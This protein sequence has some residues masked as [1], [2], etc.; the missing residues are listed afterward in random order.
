M[1]GSFRWE[2]ISVEVMK[3]GTDKKPQNILI[4]QIPRSQRTHGSLS[5]KHL[6]VVL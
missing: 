4:G 6:L 1:E 5:L 3:G 2:L